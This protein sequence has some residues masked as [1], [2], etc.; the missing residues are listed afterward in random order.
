MH[1]LDLAH[2]ALLLLPADAALCG[3]DREQLGQILIFLLREDYRDGLC[4]NRP[5]RTSFTQVQSSSSA[6]TV[7]TLTE[8]FV[9]P[10]KDRKI[11]LRARTVPLK[12]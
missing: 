8:S 10:D 9:W 3:R 12:T 5:P 7:F 1:G 4:G 6:L 11:H 2:Q